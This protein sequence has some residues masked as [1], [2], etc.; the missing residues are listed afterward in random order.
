MTFE[1]WQNGI[2]AKV[3]GTWN[4]HN[5]LEKNKQHSLDFFVL[6][7][8]LAGL[9]GN[10]GQANYA[11]ASTFLDSFVQFRHSLNLACSVVDIGVMEDV[12]YVSNDPRLYEHFR[13]AGNF[14]LK[15]Q[16]ML[17]AL[18]L[19][20]RRSKP[21]TTDVIATYVNPSQVIVGL[22]ST[23]EIM[24]P[25]NRYMFKRDSRATIYRNL[26]TKERNGQTGEDVDELK[27]F[28][29]EAALNP[30]VLE[31]QH[32]AEFLAREAGKALFSFV[33]RDP[34]TMDLELPLDSF[35]IDSLLGMELRN[36]FRHKIGVDITVR[37]IM[38]G[39]S[40]MQLGKD[41]AKYL[42]STE[43]DPAAAS[44]SHKRDF[45]SAQERYLNFKAP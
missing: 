4:L 21:S 3:Q 41:T 45:K 10:S 6:L 22:R 44:G 17:D 19:A 39:A 14:M 35:G 27:R 9:A 34:S 29:T 36:W 26:G 23:T 24:S 7:S 13:S 30:T 31:T 15:E 16:E 28:L 33:L 42:A 25:Q 8:S 40:L 43:K 1:E 32:T 2:L 37:Q 12:G 11:A 20:I 18:H 5:S 38:S